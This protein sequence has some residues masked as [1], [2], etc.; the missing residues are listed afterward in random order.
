MKVQELIS[1][2][3]KCDP[4]A[5]VTFEVGRNDNYRKAYAKLVL[6]DDGTPENDG[7]SCLRYL[8]VDYLEQK[9]F[10]YS[11]ESELLISLGQNYYTDEFFEDYVIT[12]IVNNEFT[13]RK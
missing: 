6:E 5:E 9:Q 4:K 3:Q 13:K 1:L 8:S 11:E 12:G 10:V 2:L 7:L